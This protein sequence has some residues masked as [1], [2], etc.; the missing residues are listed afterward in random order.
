MVHAYG[1]EE[2]KAFCCN[3]KKVTVHKYESF[4]KTEPKTEARDFFSGLFVAIASALMEGEPTGDYKCK[5]C[6]T[7]L[8]TPD[9]LD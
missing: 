4:S 7:N 8:S 5:V 2:T 9:Y 6:G 1:A 3:C